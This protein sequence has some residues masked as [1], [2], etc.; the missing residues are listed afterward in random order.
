MES[1]IEHPL[2]LGGYE[3]CPTCHSRGRAVGLNVARGTRT[4]KYRGRPG[5]TWVQ[6]TADHWPRLSQGAGGMGR[7]G[8]W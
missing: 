6:S 8:G 4:V 2:R 7:T 5:H 1:V 3:P